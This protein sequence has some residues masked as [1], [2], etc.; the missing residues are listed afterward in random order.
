VVEIK[1]HSFLTIIE[2][3]LETPMLL[4]SFVWLIVIVLELVYGDI[5]MLRGLG[6]LIWITFIPFF[7]L[8]LV[9]ARD[10]IKFLKK[11]WLFILAIAVPMLRFF[12]YLQQFTLMR[13]LTATLAIQI[14]WIFA[15]AD[16][17]L[18]SLRR[19][20]GRRGAGYALT[21]TI[22]VIVAGAA[23]MLFFE[24]DAPDPIG[25][26]SYPRALWWTAMQITNIG[27]GYRPITAGGEILSLAISIYAAAMFGYLTAI[28]ATF[29]VGREAKDPKSEIAG[30]KSILQLQEEVALLRKSIEEVLQFLPKE[31]IPKGQK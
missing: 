14:V 19:T 3:K 29:L 6:T 22:I 8:R 11:N 21:L 4:L 20:L 13:A 23:G 1:Q 12:S 24:K 28:L 26:H 27:S 15:S 25:I 7:C 10:K 17:G 9:T 5:P 31:H 16:I 18:R 2:H 30:Q